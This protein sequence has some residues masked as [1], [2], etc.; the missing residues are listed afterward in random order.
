M[1]IEA[2]LE[3]IADALEVIAGRSTP[4][5]KEEPAPAKEEPKAKAK[6]EPKAKAPATVT[7]GDVREALKAL[8][9]ATDA[10]TAKG[11]LAEFEAN[12]LSDLSEDVF[13]AVIK[14]AEEL[15]S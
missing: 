3:R 5:A 12:K 14:R 8:Q 2:T 10:A 4:P 7:S 6:A 9:K 15:C 1:T 13:A 11:V